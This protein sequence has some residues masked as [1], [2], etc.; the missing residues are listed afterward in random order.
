MFV[1]L[2]LP[3]YSFDKGRMPTNSKAQFKKELIEFDVVAQWKR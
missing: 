1:I 2:R 3:C